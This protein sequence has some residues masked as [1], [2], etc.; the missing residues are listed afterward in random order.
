MGNGGIGFRLVGSNDAAEEH[1]KQ[2]LAIAREIGDRHLEGNALLHSGEA[3]EQ[4]GHI[5]AAERLYEGALGLRREINHL[6]GIAEVLVALGR[7][8]VRDGRWMDAA[9]R[10][11]E[12]SQ[13]AERILAPDEVVLAAGYQS[14][15]PDA[16]P[17]LARDALVRHEPRLAAR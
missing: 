7:L 12:A 17:D 8:L 3:A 1:Q 13:L 15:I 4:Q 11:E 6:K 14:L 2:Y 9:H 16:N 5:E 10:L